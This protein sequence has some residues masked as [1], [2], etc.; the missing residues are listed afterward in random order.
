MIVKVRW[1][2]KTHLGI[3][4]QLWKSLKISQIWILITTL[5]PA[6]CGKVLD[7]ICKNLP[8]NL[9][10]P[11]IKPVRPSLPVP[12]GNHYCSSSGVS[13]PGRNKIT[14]S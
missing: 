9:S 4:I 8:D 12:F 11:I 1:D 3:F 14:L 7:E 5:E 6:S 10:M 13:K 2:S